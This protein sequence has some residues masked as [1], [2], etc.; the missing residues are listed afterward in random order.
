MLTGRRIIFVLFNLELGGAERQALILATH[1]ARREQAKV[2]VWGFNRTG[3]V[4]QLCEQAGLKWRVVPYPFQSGSAARLVALARLALIFRRAR[5]DIFLPYTFV[6][7]VVC[8][9]LWKGAGARACVWNQRDEGPAEFTA[10]WERSAVEQTSLFISNSAAGAQLLVEQ[11]GVDPAKVKVIENGIEELRSQGD[12]DAWRARLGVDDRCFVACMVA[13]IH[14]NKDHTTL[15]RAWQ[16]VVYEFNGD[17]VLVLAGRHYGAY[18]SLV[19]LTTEL[20]ITEKVCFAGQ[21]ADVSGLLSAAD[22]AV[23]SSRSEGCPNGVLESMAAGLAIAGTDVEGIRA[24]VGA[25]G[26][27]F[28]APPGDDEALAGVI[29]RLANDADLRVTIG[30]Q[31]RRRVRERYG[32]ERMCD[33][34]VAVLNQ[35]L[36]M[37]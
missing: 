34:T 13:N 29:L 23:F 31:N 19:A 2:E 26:A 33:E 21:V 36:V 32:A 16:R 37:T 17:A 12:R 3:P 24:V 35:L 25:R 5:P 18:E 4:A 20:G 1:L 27:E 11:L 30:A 28:L 22:V 8:G 15:L 9:L 10:A 6:P 7:N 14:D